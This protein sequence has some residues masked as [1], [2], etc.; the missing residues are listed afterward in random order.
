MEKQKNL[1]DFAKKELSQDAFLRWLFENYN[2]D[3]ECVRAAAV[4]LLDKLG[5]D[6]HNINKIE[7]F[8]QRNHIDITVYVHS[9]DTLQALYIEDKTMSSEHNQLKNYN[10][11]IKKQIPRF[12]IKK[13][14]KVYYKTYILN[15]DERDRVDDAGWTIIKFDD[16]AKFWNK[17]LDSS[18]LIL[19]SYAEHIKSIERDLCN[20]ERCIENN[21]I[22]WKSYFEKVLI[23]EAKKISNCSCGADFTRFGYSYMWIRPKGYKEGYPYLEI[24]SRDCA[25]NAF[26]ARIL[27]YSL[28]EKKYP[29]IRQAIVDTIDANGKTGVF[30]PNKG[31][32]KDKQ[33][34]VTRK[35]YEYLT[36][37]EY[38]KVF[39]AVVKEYLDIMNKA[40][41]K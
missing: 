31:Q 4:D 36:D 29:N 26:A 8:S 17:Y 14:K 19:R 13:V 23:P 2:C 1:F 30:K 24:R 5:I 11:S 12:G 32:K 41:P 22:A 10:N 28:N 35:K 6:T 39:R 20:T 16:I 21:V 38:M 25:D 40:D 7:T 9:D 27:T 33:K 3:E 18:N 15:D 37:D 34:G